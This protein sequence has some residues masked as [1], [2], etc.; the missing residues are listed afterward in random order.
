MQ[1]NAWEILTNNITVIFSNTTPVTFIYNPKTNSIYTFH[2]HYMIVFCDM[3]GI[4]VYIIS[5]FLIVYRIE[6]EDNSKYTCYF[7]YY[8]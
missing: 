2:G 7:L 4:I 8:L 5:Q 3:G 6:H 1:N